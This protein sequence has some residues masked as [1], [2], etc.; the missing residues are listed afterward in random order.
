MREAANAGK[1]RR[2]EDQA[3]QRMR[4]LQEAVPPLASRRG[5]GG[6]ELQSADEQLAEIRS[7]DA[8]HAAGT[9]LSAGDPCLICRRPLPDD[10]QP[11]APADPDA[12]RAAERA[13]RKRRRQSDD[14]ATEFAQ[15]QANA[16]SAQEDYKNRQSAAQQAQARLEQACQDAA[17]AMRDLAQRQWDDGTR[18]PGEREFGT[19]L[20]AACSRLS[21]ADDDDQDKLPSTSARQLLGPARTAG[22]GTGRCRRRRPKK[23][24]GK[25]RPMP[26]GQRTSSRFSRKPTTRRRPSSPQPGNGTLTLRPNSAAT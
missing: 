25:A 22:A 24:P 18:S 15:A 13:V 3:L 5:Q 20:Q 1:A 26:P 16:A 17:A 12:L 7:H 2:E 23:P 14:A 11:P 4:D 21:E 19:M 6:H 9:G 8:A 10:Y